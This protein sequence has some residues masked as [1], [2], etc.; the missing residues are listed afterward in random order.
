V[1]RGSNRIAHYLS[2]MHFSRQWPK[3]LLGVTQRSV[4]IGEEADILTA[5]PERCFG[6]A[7]YCIAKFPKL[8]YRLSLCAGSRDV[9]PPRC[10][11]DQTCRARQRGF[12]L[13]NKPMH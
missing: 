4:A 5:D 2:A 7:N 6:T 3:A 12:G 13:C 11:C 1:R 8:V 9:L 10:P